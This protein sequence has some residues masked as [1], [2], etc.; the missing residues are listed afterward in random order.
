MV[1]PVTAVVQAVSGVRRTTVSGISGFV[2]VSHLKSEHLPN[3]KG[4]G[5]SFFGKD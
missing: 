4:G 1:L 3:K 2:F 5:V